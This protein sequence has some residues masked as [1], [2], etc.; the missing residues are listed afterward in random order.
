MLKISLLIVK[1]EY[2]LAYRHWPEML[3][4]WIFFLMII[5][6]FPL[7]LS[8]DPKLLTFMAPAIIWIGI[9]LAILLSSHTVFQ[10]EVEGAMIEQWLL[11]PVNFLYFVTLKLIAHWGLSLL[12]LLILLPFLAAGFHLTFHATRILCFTLLLA[13]P[14]LTFIG[15]I[16][17]ALTL[18]LRQNGV[19]LALL[20][21]PFYIPIL[22]FA[23]SSVSNAMADLP[24]SAPLALL[25]AIL[26]IALPLAPLAV[27][28]ALKIGVT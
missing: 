17:S 5:T 28:A 26:L 9:L 7:A 12:P 3:Q 16:F 15:A 8:P 14:S 10:R 19:L 22:I 25:G 18:S 23:A 2:L 20:V 27:S 6:L 21:L 4:P 24:V 13:T 11:S 1:R